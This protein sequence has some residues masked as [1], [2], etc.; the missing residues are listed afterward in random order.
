M[1][2][3]LVLLLIM[4]A[5]SAFG[6][7]DAEDDIFN[8]E[9]F[10]KSVEQG[11]KEDEKYAPE[12][13]FGGE[14][15]LLTTLSAPPEFDHYLGQGYLAGKP[16]LKISDPRTGSL[17]ISYSV[18]NYF[19]QTADDPAY[20]PEADDLLAVEFVLSEF[21]VSFDIAKAVFIKLGNQINSWGASFFWTPVDFINRERID[22]ERTLDIR[23]GI[24]ALKIHIPFTGANL[25][26]IVDF[27]ETVSDNLEVRDIAN[28]I[29]AGLRFDFTV[30][31]AQI[32]LMGYIDAGPDVFTNKYGIDLA[33][34][35]AGFDI[36][37]EH[38]FSFISS[39]DTAFRYEDYSF[40]VGFERPFG[41]LKK[42]SVQAEFFYNQ[43]G[44]EDESAADAL[45]AGEYVPFYFGTYYVFA[46]LSKQDFLSDI[47]D[48]GLSTIINF[49]DL[50]YT[51][52]LA[53]TFNIPD[54]FPLT[55]ALSFNGGDAG[56]EFTLFL[57]N[58]ITLS[59]E[60]RFA[61]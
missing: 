6:Q 29:N 38:A 41:E 44:R 3:I 21:Y 13:L 52:K 19:F 36:Y 8:T 43:A 27:S 1:K 48:A 45:L 15:V 16:F 59:A 47:M 24:P 25:F 57:N 14:F 51:I 28:T 37:T 60:V 33:T 17:Y 32:G 50:S 18:S 2:K 55:C 9:E 7:E 39:N 20:I 35:I 40:A 42:W 5:F 12:F 26:S 31:D 56:D 54:M 30:W 34:N 22:T 53:L 23:T 4:N 49:S 11:I 58:F 46:R 61:F 10:D